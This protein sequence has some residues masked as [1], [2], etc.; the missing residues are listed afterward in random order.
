MYP[1]WKSSGT[2]R[3]ANAFHS[4]EYSPSSRQYTAFYGVQGTKFQF[5]RC[6]QGMAASPYHFSTAISSIFTSYQFI[7]FCSEF[8]YTY[9][10]IDDIPSN[11]LILYVDD[12]LIAVDLASLKKRFHFVL[13]SLMKYKLKI[14]FTKLKI[15]T[16]QFSFLGSEYDLKRR[17]S[18]IKLDRR[19]ALLSLVI[20][21]SRHQISLE[22]TTRGSLDQQ[23]N[24]I[25][26]GHKII[27]SKAK[28][29][30]G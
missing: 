2:H 19:D 12:L 7:A 21:K 8:E 18:G 28:L 10:P 24:V 14:N 5:K 29:K 1:T 6:Y 22:E 25:I 15:G 20:R 16:Y 9:D 26:F 30:I 13:Y 11:W 27:H 23:K 17:Q 4:I 3:V